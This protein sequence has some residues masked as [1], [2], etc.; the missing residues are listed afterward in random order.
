MREHG[1]ALD[2]D[3]Y[4]RWR[5]RLRD[6]P[7]TIGWG[8]VALFLRHLP[9]DSETKREMDPSAAWSR[10][11]HLIALLIDTIG[12]LFAKDYE[13]LQ[14]PGDAKPFE[15]AEAVTPMDYERVLARF[16]GGDS[17]G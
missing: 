9:Y 10:T 12:D 17:D 11:E 7:S 2:F 15:T 13:H 5:V 16:R 6:V 4:D 8:A 1:D 14:R 3:L